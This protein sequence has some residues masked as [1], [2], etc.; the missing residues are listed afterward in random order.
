LPPKDSNA[1]D[2]PQKP[3]DIAAGIHHVWVNATGNWAYFL[4][5]VDRI[6]WLRLFMKVAERYDWTTV[7]FCQMTTHVHAIIRVGD[8][9]LAEGMRYLN[10]EYSKEFNARHDRCGQFV[11]RRYGSRRIEGAADLLGAFAYV[12]LNPVKE[13]M[14]P[15]PQDWR[16]SSYATTLGLTSDFPFVDTGIVLSEVGGSVDALRELVGARALPLSPTAVSGN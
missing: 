9:T 3:R 6:T 8:A 12:V 16:W 10:R 13:R 11:R 2:V 1:H 5:D 7:V 14:C 15:R 4:D